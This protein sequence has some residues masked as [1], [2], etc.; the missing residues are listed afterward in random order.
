MLQCHRLRASN[1][2]GSACSGMRSVMQKTCSVRA[3]P[4]ME[5][6]A[7]ADSPR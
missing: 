6:E 4:A 5:S 3:L 7:K 1:C 2:P